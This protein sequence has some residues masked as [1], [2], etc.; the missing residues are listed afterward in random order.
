MDRSKPAP[1]TDL[2]ARGD[3]G[4]LAAEARKRRATTEE[5][6][7][8]LPAAEARELV[9]AHREDDGTLTLVMSSAAWA[10]RVRYLAAELGV[11]RLKV[12]VAPPGGAP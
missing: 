2:L 4:R 8:K 3:L 7:L 9:A 12:R 6:R 5:V 1:F 11:P 10:A